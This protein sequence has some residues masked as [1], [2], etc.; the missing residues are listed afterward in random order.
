MPGLPVPFGSQV[1]CAHGGTATASAANPRVTV[2]GTPTVLI[3]TPYM[4]AGCAMP[5]PP[6]GNGPCVSGQ[7]LSGT[8][9]VLSAGQPLVIQTGSSLCTPTGTP[10]MALAPNP[11]VTAM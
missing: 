1:L 6:N 7:W 10:M 11:R 9:R 2:G 5:P 8:T 3:S 4:V